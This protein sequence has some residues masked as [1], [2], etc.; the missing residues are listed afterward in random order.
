[1]LACILPLIPHEESSPW[2]AEFDV[3]RRETMTRNIFNSKNALIF[4]GVF[5][6]AIVLSMVVFY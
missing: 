5:L 4:E 3:R 2:G 1:M 6:L